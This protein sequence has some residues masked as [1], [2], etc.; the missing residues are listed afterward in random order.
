MS[1]AVHLTV[2]V[3]AIALYVFHSLTKVPSIC[4]P[5]SDCDRLKKTAAAAVYD[6]VPTKAP[7]AQGVILQVMSYILTRSTLGPYFCR[8]LLN[9]N[10]LHRLRELASEINLP[11]LHFPVVRIKPDIDANMSES[12]LDHLKDFYELEEPPS[13]K[14]SSHPASIRDYAQAYRTGKV[15]P[16]EVMRRLLDKIK[17]WERKRPTFVIFSSINESDVMDMAYASD[18]RSQ[19]S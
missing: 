16:S 17:Y 18:E 5:L 14:D 15:K 8:Y 9:S 19:R 11:P 4:Q 13:R 3:L 10:N 12:S 1:Y 7:V 2:L 6:I